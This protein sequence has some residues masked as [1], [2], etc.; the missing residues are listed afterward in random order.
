MNPNQYIQENY[1]EIKKWLYNITKGEKPHLYDDFIHE[2]IMI[3][4]QHDKAQQAINSDTARYFL[5][6]IGLNQWRSSTSPFHYQYR[7]SFKDVTIKEEVSEEYDVTGD[8][9]EE[10]IM[11][12]LDEMYKGA[13][14]DRYEAI[15]MMMYHANNSNYSLLGR[16]LGIP[17]TTVR[18]VYL[19]GLE[20][21][22]NKINNK[23]KLYSNG[24]IDNSNI[25]SILSSWD[26][27]GSDNK[28]H[29]LSLAS[30]IFKTGYF[31]TT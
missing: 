23:I 24:I 28:Q 29:T 21:L 1:S 3:F 20:K 9:M 31:R 18:K 30:E 19:R 16:Q 22:K 26:N 6:R 8:V 10:L 4:L 7:D 17:H 12:G 11:S 2:V 15:I 27:L 5:V 14:G 13:G 25:T